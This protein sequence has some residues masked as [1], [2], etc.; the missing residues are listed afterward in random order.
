MI[1]VSLSAWVLLKWR[2]ECECFVWLA[3]LFALLLAVMPLSVS[4]GTNLYVL[5]D[6]ASS[7]AVAALLIA[8]LAPPLP[9]LHGPVETS[10][11]SSVWAV[12]CFLSWGVRCYAGVWLA[13]SLVCELSALARWDTVPKSH[14]R[15]FGASRTC[16]GCRCMPWASCLTRLIR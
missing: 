16:R 11:S 13:D 6:L 15:G 7:H 14:R 9:S 5:V 3:I 4:C 2:C 8:W 10:S 12:S 1:V